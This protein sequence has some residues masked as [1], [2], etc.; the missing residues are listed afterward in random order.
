MDVSPFELKPDDNESWYLGIGV[1][2]SYGE[3][4]RTLNPSNGR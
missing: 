4:Y 2:S 1:L 3:D